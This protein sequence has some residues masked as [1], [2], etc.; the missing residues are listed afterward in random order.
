[1]KIRQ[2]LAGLLLTLAYAAPSPAQEAPKYDMGKVQL[3]FLRLA[4]D[5]KAADASAKVSREHRAFVEKLMAEGKIAVSG[6]VSGEGDLREIM[7]IKTE[8]LEEA[9][10]ATAAL[11]AVKAG[12]LKPEVLSWFAARNYI[13]PPLMPLTP[14]NYVF[15]ILVRGPQWTAAET[16]ETRKLQEGHMANIN[17]LAESG[18]LVLAGPFFDGGE[19]R[20]VFIFKVDT[21][22][23]AQSLTDTDP[24]VKAGRLK[25]ELHRW[26]VPKGVL[27]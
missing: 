20:G 10:Q 25:I 6:E 22:Q 14:T 24:A 23:E 21:L 9:R 18:K 1:M 8:S 2:L 19:R 11:P 16:E 17:R 7:V 26:S 12:M 5:W 27:K 3:V 4:P 15:G 13:N